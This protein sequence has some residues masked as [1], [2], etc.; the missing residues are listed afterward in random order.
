MQ[1]ATLTALIFV[2]LQGAPQASFI[3]MRNTEVSSGVV[4]VNWHKRMKK[5]RA[6]AS[7]I[8]PSDLHCHIPRLVP[9]R[10]H[11]GLVYRG[12]R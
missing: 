3:G 8:P 1:R 7:T 2:A 6:G 10:C 9:M 11:R 5:K 4:Q 12:P